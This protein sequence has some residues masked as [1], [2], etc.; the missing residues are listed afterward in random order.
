MIITSAAVALG[1]SQPSY[2]YTEGQMMANVEI[3]V[4]ANPQNRSV[5][6][7]VVSVDDT[8]VSK[9]IAGV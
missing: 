6:V 5:H 1:F 2:T 4:T 8:A 7:I 3:T 9:Y